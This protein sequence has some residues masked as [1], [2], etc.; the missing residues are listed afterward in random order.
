MI[1]A[2][3]IDSHY[4]LEHKNWARK[5]L[6]AVAEIRPRLAVLGEGGPS[7]GVITAMKAPPNALVVVTQVQLISVVLISAVETS[8]RLD[9]IPGVVLPPGWNSWPN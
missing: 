7:S 3:P 9:E 1:D 4:L 5:N 2:Y 8:R 6:P